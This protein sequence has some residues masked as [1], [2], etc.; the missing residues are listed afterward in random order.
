MIDS[1]ISITCVLRR[2]FAVF[3]RSFSYYLMT[4]FLEPILYL[5]AFG[6]GVGSLVGDLKVEGLSLSYRD[7]VFSGIL[8]QTTLFQGFFEGAY[9]G[10]FRMNYQRVFQAIATTPVTLSEVLWAE[11][12]WDAAKATMAAMVVATIGVGLGS[13]PPIA[14]LGLL[15]VCFLSALT[16]ASLGILAAAFSRNIDQLSYPQFLIVFPMFLFC[17]VFYPIETLPSGVQVVAWFFP[18]TPINSLM[19]T[20]AIG[21]PFQPG[22]VVLSV[23]WLV[24]LVFVARRSM[25]KRLIK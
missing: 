17:G 5:I 2:Y 23:A 6:L 15:P 4:T 19:R 3:K 10:F 22:A 12:L 7:F 13:F 1:L 25:L 24:A 21:L 14:L 18:L 20:L 8:A 16:F 9:G 11:L